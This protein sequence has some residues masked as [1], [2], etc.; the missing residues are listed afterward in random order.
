MISDNISPVY[1]AWPRHLKS[2]LLILS[3]TSVTSFT[4]I[5]AG[6]RS[7]GVSSSFDFACACCGSG[8]KAEIAPFSPLISR[9]TSSAGLTQSQL[10][11]CDWDFKGHGRCEERKCLTSHRCW[12]IF[13]TSPSTGVGLSTALDVRHDRSTTSLTQSSAQ[14]LAFGQASQGAV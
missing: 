11:V 13:G 6:E 4:T 8:V 9:I 1:R 5:E 3:E 2:H 7:C 12:E 10:Y 14:S